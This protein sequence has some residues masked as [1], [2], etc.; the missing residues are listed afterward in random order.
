[1]VNECKVEDIFRYILLLTV[2]FQ[3][4]VVFIRLTDVIL[5]HHWKRHLVTKIN[6]SFDANIAKYFSGIGEFCKSKLVLRLVLEPV[7][8]LHHEI[9]TQI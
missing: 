1:M 9:L 7:N 4:S 2:S 3:P 5:A 8:E 6:R